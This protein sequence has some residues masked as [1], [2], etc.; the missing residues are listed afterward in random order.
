MRILYVAMTRAKERLIMTAAFKNPQKELEKFCGTVAD[1]DGVSRGNSFAHW[2]LQS[3]MSNGADENS[4]SRAGIELKIVSRQPENVPE[5]APVQIPAQADFALYKELE[6]RLCFVYPCK[7]ATE[8]PAKLSVSMLSHDFSPAEAFKTRPA[9][10]SAVKDDKD[11]VTFGRGAGSALHKFMQL[12]DYSKAASDISGEINRLCDRG[13]L[14]NPDAALLD[15]DRLANFFAGSLAKRILASQ[16]V[17]REF[18]FMADASVSAE[19]CHLTGENGES[20]LL[21]GIADCVFFENDKPIV[22]DYK[23]DRVDDAPVFIARYGKQLRLYRDML[24]HVLKVPVASCVIY[25]FWP[26]M[27]INI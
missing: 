24:S 1:P 7:K 3:A 18:R 12:C 4:G 26:Q 22:V 10:A 19:S 5:E 17:L 16:R 8:I 15:T 25:A 6:K 9:F 23:T 21:Q 2:I 20:T 13:S 11:K 27:E 14:T